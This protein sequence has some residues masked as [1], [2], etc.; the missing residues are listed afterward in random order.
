MQITADSTHIKFNVSPFDLY[1]MF[2][3]IL[4]WPV[5]QKLKGFSMSSRL[6]ND[7]WGWAIFS[8]FRYFH[9]EAQ[10]QITLR[11]ESL[12]PESGLV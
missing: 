7:V 2:D 6:P 8:G 3:V 4:P 1:Q 10:H 5:F 11:P 9:S 12:F